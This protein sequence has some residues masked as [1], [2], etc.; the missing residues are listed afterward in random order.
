MGL[1]CILDLSRGCIKSS[2][3]A[4]GIWFE[5]LATSPLI[6]TKA[7]IVANLLFIPIPNTYLVAFERA[8]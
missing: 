7:N 1:P 6:C 2:L 3:L 4:S 8:L 5:A